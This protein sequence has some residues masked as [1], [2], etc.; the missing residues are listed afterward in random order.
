MLQERRGK[1]VSKDR[2]GLLGT[3]SKLLQRG[4]RADLRFRNLGF[5]DVRLVRGTL[6]ASAFVNEVVMPKLTA[7]RQA[8]L[9]ANLNTKGNIQ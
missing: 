1:E 4:I 5:V 9:A 8:H 3:D 2:R 6:Q 7:F